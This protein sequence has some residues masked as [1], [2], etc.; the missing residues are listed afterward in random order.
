MLTSVVQAIHQFSLG[1][2]LTKLF[3]QLLTTVIQTESLSYLLVTKYLMHTR[4]SGHLQ[5]HSF[6]IGKLV[7]PNHLKAPSF[8]FLLQGQ[9]LKSYGSCQNH[10]VD[11]ITNRVVNIFS[12]PRS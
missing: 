4:P 10:I 12:G 7:N 8:L 9:Y 3:I 1:N 5:R 6:H 2:S 11:I